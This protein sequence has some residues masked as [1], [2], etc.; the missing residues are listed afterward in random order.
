V[1]R[2]HGIGG[3][4]DLAQEKR[5]GDVKCSSYEGGQIEYA[6]AR[7]HTKGSTPETGE[8]K[9]PGEKRSPRDKV[10]TQGGIEE[11]KEQ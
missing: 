11:G 8:K 3:E 4:N 10:I 1:A 2:R 5:R 6:Q 9:Y 7:G